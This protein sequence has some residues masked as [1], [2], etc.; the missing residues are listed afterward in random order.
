[1]AEQEG[2]IKIDR[3][4]LQWGWFKNPNTAHLFLTLLLKANY[5][6][7][8][9]DGKAIKVGSLVTSFQTLGEIS[10][11]TIQQCRT[12]LKH[13]KTTGEVTSKSYPKYQVITIVN[14]KKYQ[15]VTRLL[16]GNQQ[17]T[18]RQLTSNQQQEKEGK[19]GRRKERIPPKSPTGG[20]APS[21]DKPKRGTDEFR[22]RSHL[23]LKPDEGTVDDIPEMYRDMY[24]TFAD[25]WRYRNQ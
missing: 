25:Y 3:N 4:M 19:K 20:L 16:T 9:F 1:M 12:A 10:G 6:D 8:V 11:L 15:S 2:F 22:V 23:L 5:K 7:M 18:N 13:L 21:G 24:K 17:A 14:Y